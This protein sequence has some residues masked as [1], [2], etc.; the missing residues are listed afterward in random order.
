MINSS[1]VNYNEEKRAISNLLFKFPFNT[2]LVGYSMLKEAIFLT[3]CCNSSRVNMTKDVYNK[4]ADKRN[5]NKNSVEKCIKYV[6]DSV[7][8]SMIS[9]KDVVCP[10]ILIKN[11][12]IDGK[13]KSFIMAIAEA[14]KFLNIDD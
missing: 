4:I 13:P 5:I 7:G 9:A 6:I 11:A 1:L 10:N 2:S 14:V 8:C 12:L 3:L